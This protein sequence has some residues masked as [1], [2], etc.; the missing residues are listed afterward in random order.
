MR[1]VIRIARYMLGEWLWSVKI[2][3][4]DIATFQ[5]RV[6]CRNHHRRFYLADNDISF[7][8]ISAATINSSETENHIVKYW[9]THISTYICNVCSCALLL[10][11]HSSTFEIMWIQSLM[12]HIYNTHNLEPF[13]FQIYVLLIAVLDLAYSVVIIFTTILLLFFSIYIEP[14]V[15]EILMHRK[16]SFLS[17]IDSL[18]SVNEKSIISG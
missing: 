17:I 14:L 2:D 9:D 16:Q 4:G 3:V 8:K 12:G 13:T 5:M 15:Y 18:G 6:L 11:V 1:C 7:C 10:A